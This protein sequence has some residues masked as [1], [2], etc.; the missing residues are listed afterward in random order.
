M[1]DFYERD[2]CPCRGCDPKLRTTGVLGSFSAAS[3]KWA[4]LILNK[5][6]SAARAQPSDRQALF[7]LV[8]SVHFRP[9]F[10]CFHLLFCYS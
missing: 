7:S 1:C 5:A 4:A 9:T 10:P 3:Q 2:I 8:V 6:P